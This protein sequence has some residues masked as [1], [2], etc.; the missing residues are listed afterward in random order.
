MEVNANVEQKIDIT[1]VTDPEELE[2]L[3]GPPEDLRKGYKELIK[4]ALEA[5][6]RLDQ[7]KHDPLSEYDHLWEQ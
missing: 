7:Y 5:L 4:R 6:A 3:A 1:K 2:R